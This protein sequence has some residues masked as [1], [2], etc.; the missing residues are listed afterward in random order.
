MIVQ[1]LVNVILLG[2]IYAT[3]GIGFSLI[4]GVMN[5]I[6]LAHGS[7]VM[8]GAY[9]TY[10]LFSTLGLDPFLTLPVSIGLGFIIGYLSQ[11]YLFNWTIHSGVLMSSI[12]TY[13]F[14][15]ILANIILLIFKGDTKAVTP[16]YSGLGLM[17]GDVV[18][19]YIRLIIFAASI[20][21]TIIM[22]HLITSTRMGNS[23]RAT[24]LNRDAAR[25][26][27]IRI[28]EAY[29]VTYG[30]AA[31]LAAAS[32]SLIASVYPIY[33]AME[34]PFLSK[35]FVIAVLGG[36]GSMSGAIV[37]GLALALAETFGVVIFGPSYQTLVG[38][39]VFILVIVLRPHGLVGKR[40]Y[41]EL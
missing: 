6:N 31:A 38:F 21:L 1:H 29:A 17:V 32:G 16:T 30:L 12:Q 10:Y 2:G 7:L 23:I 24:S 33:P 37:G 4:Y 18:V 35:A 25:M 39:A 19:P 36:L 20:V 9:V 11:K 14:N 8:V 34:G 5:V 3:V 41:A 13:G 15:L 22:F 27:G 28:S 40:F 26:V